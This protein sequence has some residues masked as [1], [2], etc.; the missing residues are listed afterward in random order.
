MAVVWCRELPKE[1]SQSGKFRE[2]YEYT[3]AWLVRTDTLDTPLPDI[4]NAAGISY[5]DSHP[6]DASC[7]ALEFTTQ[8]A[9]DSGLLF[10]VRTKYS[11][12]PAD[13]GDN[14]EEEEQEQTVPGI[15]RN[16][17]WSGSSTVRSVPIYKDKDGDIIT[18]SAGDPLEGLEGDEAEFRLTL[19][20]YALS[21]A[22]WMECGRLYTNAVNSDTWNGGEPRTWKCQGL[23]A[24]L[25]TVNKEGETFIFW[26]VTTEFAYRADTWD[27]KPWDIGFHER[28]T[29]DG[30]PSQAGTKRRAIVGQDK[31]PVKQPV[32][33]ANGIALP[34]GTPPEVI[35]DGAGVQIYESLAFIPVFGQIYTPVVANE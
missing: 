3:R 6:D 24:Q 30:T 29:D 19:T 23:S 11:A 7:K 18:N 12:P 26:E 16:P 28:V 34:A 4:T 20:G 32:A 8:A 10:M 13:Q 21:H 27:L 33:L 31:K 9:D 17:V 22:S 25:Q 5:L 35:N 14:E 15:M 1:R 2:T